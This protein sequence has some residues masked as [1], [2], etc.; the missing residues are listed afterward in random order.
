MFENK[1]LRKIVGAKRQEITREL[2]KLH[3]AELHVLHSS[4]EII[5]KL[6]LRRLRWA[7]HVAGMELSRNAY[8]IQQENLR[9]RDLQGRKQEDNI[10]M[11]SK[12]VGCDAGNWMDLAQDRIMLGR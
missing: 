3:T 5:T 9:E 8:R 11:D 1:V 10:K 6:Q 2:K 4:P 12:E 7:G